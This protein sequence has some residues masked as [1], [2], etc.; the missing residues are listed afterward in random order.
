MIMDSEDVPEDPF[1]FAELFFGK[2]VDIPTSEPDM[3]QWL[4]NN[5]VK[6]DKIRLGW[7]SGDD[8]YTGT[9]PDSWYL[10]QWAAGCYLVYISDDG[11]IYSL[12]LC[13]EN[14]QPKKPYFDAWAVSAREF[15]SGKGWNCNYIYNVDIS[16]GFLFYFINW[17]TNP[18]DT[19]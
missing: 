9:K 4:L 1:R 15:N 11:Y 14:K 17:N 13:R 19:K 10:T 8:K 6:E 16:Q 3:E 2:D 12:Q 5:G 18:F 7:W